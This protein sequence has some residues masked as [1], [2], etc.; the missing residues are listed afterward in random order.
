MSSAVRHF[1]KFGGFQL[2]TAEHLL[3]RQNG[4]VVP[5]KPK[6][7]ETLELLV[8]ERG[9]LI[10]K[11][12]LMQKLWPDAIVEESN[13]SQNIYLLRKALG[14]DAGGRNYI[15]N[16]PK[17]GYRFTVEVEEVIIEK[18]KSVGTALEESEKK[19]DGGG[20]TERP[21][22]NRAAAPSVWEGPTPARLGWPRTSLLLLVLALL[23][24]VLI[25]SIMR[26]AHRAGQDGGR[27]VALPFQNVRL[28]RITES[29]DISDAT[30]S[31]DGKQVAYST[32][33]NGIW[34][35]NLAT[36][37]R[38]QLLPESELE[39]RAGLSFSR[40]GDH[41][42]F[43]SDVKGKKAQLMRV[44]VLGGPPHKLIEDFWTAVAISPDEKQFA[45]MRQYT[46][47][48]EEALII[49][50]GSRERV[51]AKRKIPDYFA[52]WGETVAWSPDGQRLACIESLQ[53]NNAAVVS[54]VIVNAADGAQVRLPNQGRNWNNLDDVT[55]LPQGNGLIVVAREDFSSTF[56]VWRV[57]YPD[58]AWSKV[59]NDLNDYAKVSVSFDGS[60]LV[61]TQRSDFSNLWLLAQG[62]LRRA[63]QIT[64]GNG[65]TD[66]RSGLSWT[67]DGHVVFA[68][69]ASGSPEIW[70][71]DAD[72]TNLKQLTYGSEASTQ[73]FVS[74]D[75]HYVV[76]KSY[77]DNKPHIWR[78]DI[79]G[80]NPVQLTDGV[81]EEWPVV[82]PD[83]HNVIY[84]S[85]ST[86]FSTVWSIPVAGGAPTQLTDRFATWFANVS[87]DGKLLAADCYNA[88]SQSPW[89]LGIFP[90]TGGQ[91]VTSFPNTTYRGL[92]RWTPDSQSVVYMDNSNASVWKQPIHGGAPVKVI[93]LMP[94][95]RIYNFAFSPNNT[96]LVIARGRQQ[97]DALLIE[98][99]NSH[100][101]LEAKR[102]ALEE[103]SGRGNVMN[104]D[105]KSGPKQ[106][107]SS[108]VVENIGRRVGI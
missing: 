84:T 54:V 93:S 39:G 103:L 41:L 11:N 4:E 78:M 86:P 6:V 59:T 61:T 49:S 3:Y 1:Y 37:S 67:S 99:I 88:E 75:G 26:F 24:G 23:G 77:R 90:I 22:E 71:M 2:D 57:S 64:F 85:L 45:F 62:D 10:G 12:E 60:R 104:N 52:L 87:P 17:R 13:L 102:N 55:W 63:R 79:D 20:I 34:I 105:M 28:K 33:K 27:K 30:I 73:P 92:P 96:Q 48:G 35:L 108:Q 76:F 66:G 42:Y 70:I 50:D 38:L 47:E 72:G 91:P 43:H 89:Q 100:I 5:L 97:S 101:R 36:G 25:F 106:P 98:D 53:H 74:P 107:P 80:T 56:Q 95:E 46:Q 32:N 29:G 8:R 82:T 68:S 15:E 14:A 16:V 7:V 21:A 83:G 44:P 65:H 19:E 58:G 81:G 51:V 40:D 31:P 18:S 69:N 94:D 9:H